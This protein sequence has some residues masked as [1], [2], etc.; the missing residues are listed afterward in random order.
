MRNGHGR[1]HLLSIK[2][3]LLILA[4]VA[5]SLT[6][7]CP[8]LLV[9]IGSCSTGVGSAKTVALVQSKYGTNNFGGATATVAFTSNLAASHNVIACANWANNTGAGTGIT[10]TFSDSQGKT[11]VTDTTTRSAVASTNYAEIG[12]ECGHS[13][14]LSTA[15]ADTVTCTSTGSAST[16]IVCMA[17]EVN[18]NGGTLDLDQR[19]G[20][21]SSVSSTTPTA[22]SITPSQATTFAVALVIQDDG[23]GN[24]TPLSIGSGWTLTGKQGGGNED[25]AAEHRTLATTAAV[26]GNWTSTASSNHYAANVQ[27]YKSN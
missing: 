2:S 15:A 17:W 19:N 26:T 18:P 3:A 8:L 21:T 16:G 10:F 22:G 27:N 12:V 5:N 1:Q 20:A 23:L 24:N 6:A 13:T 11:Y 9:G 25:D 14:Q 7:Q 4:L